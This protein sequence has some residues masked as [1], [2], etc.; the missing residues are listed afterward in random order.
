MTDRVSKVALAS[1]AVILSAAAFGLYWSRRITWRKALIAGVT[2]SSL[3]FGCYAWRYCRHSKSSSPIPSP[4]VPPVVKPHIDPIP[5]PSTFKI[6]HGDGSDPVV[7]RII[8]G[9]IEAQNTDVVVNAANSSLRGGGGV[10]NAIHK[11]GGLDEKGNEIIDVECLKVLAQRKQKPLKVGKSVI[12]PA[13]EMVATWCV[14]TVGP[15]GPKCNKEKRAQLTSAYRTSLEIT[16]GKQVPISK[17]E[18]NVLRTVQSISFP[19]VSTGIFHFPRRKAALIAMRTISDF[20]KSHPQL[21]EVRIVIFRDKFFNENRCA[22]AV[23]VQKL[24]LKALA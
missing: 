8:E 18:P 7:I 3:L 17:E 11:A 5:L 9:S 14:H 19:L 2:P 4:I 24:G 10:D 15:T 13:G 21:T 20:L 23:A 1:S 16:E 22:Y 6:E 12:T